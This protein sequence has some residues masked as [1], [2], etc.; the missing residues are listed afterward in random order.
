MLKRFHLNGNAIGISSTDL[1]VRLTYIILSLHP[2]LTSMK[3]NE[4]VVNFHNMSSICPW[5]LCSHSDCRYSSLML[6]HM[7]LDAER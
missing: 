4:I 6:R 3:I 7:Y 2:F 1:K 5:L